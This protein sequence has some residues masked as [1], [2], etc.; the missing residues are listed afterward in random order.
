MTAIT[1]GPMCVQGFPGWR[2]TGARPLGEED[3]LLLDVN[4]PIQPASA[5]LPVLVEFHGGGY[6]Q[7]N[8]ESYAGLPL[9]EASKGN[10]VIVNVQYRLGAY[11]F[12]NAAA[13]R[14]DG[15]ANVGLLD[16]RSALN[17][18]NRHIQAFGGDPNRVT[19]SGGSAGGGS[20]TAQ[21]MM[22]GGVSNPP[23]HAAIAEYPWWQ[24]YHDSA[25]L[26][27]QYK[28]LLTAANCSNLACLR[29]LPSDQLVTATQD[30][31]NLGYNSSKQYYG[32]GDFYFG[33]SVDG[34]ILRDL[35]SNEFKRGHFTKIPLITTRNAYEGVS[36]TNRSVTTL[37]GLQQDIQTLFPSAKN[38]FFARLFQL[39]PRSAFNSTFFQHQQIVG[40]YIINCPSYYIATALSD[41]GVPVYKQI[42]NAGSQLHGATRDI[43]FNP[44]YGFR[45]GDNATLAAVLKEWYISFVMTHNPNNVSNA[46][47][48]KP[49][50]P[51]YLEKAEPG[52]GGR[53]QVLQV[54]QT[55]IAA[56]E[57]ADVNAQCDFWHGM[58][59]VVSN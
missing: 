5:R 9:V 7:G 10:I 57:D 32:Y 22:Y 38:S 49:R 3:C 14:S 39:Y 55:E 36:F 50:W 34:D 56:V 51:V 12:L 30:V 16:Q 42:F 27:S 23:F 44:A 47:I 31:Y 20:V 52:V 19:I 58:S 59:Y 25:T 24:P 21:M 8:S 40:D 53:F 48:T 4:V 28:Q 2:T 29:S 41:Y 18:V 46:Q 43:I 6:V 1:Q 45:A 35:P 33:P 17:W 11:G 15:T 13:V 37:A 54:N 26:D